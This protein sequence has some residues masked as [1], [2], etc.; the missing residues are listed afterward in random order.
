MF[1]LRISLTKN[2][3]DLRLQMQYCYGNYFLMVCILEK[4]AEFWQSLEFFCTN[5][6][7]IISHCLLPRKI[8]L[9]LGNFRRSYAILIFLLRD[10]NYLQN[11]MRFKKKDLG[12]YLFFCNNA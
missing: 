8:A 2:M 5:L 4:I 11:A 6:Y 1:L 10:F 7:N 9:R 12:D 3:K